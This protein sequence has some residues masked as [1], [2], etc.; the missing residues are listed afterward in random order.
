M[1]KRADAKQAHSNAHRE[2]RAAVAADMRRRRG[3]SDMTLAEH[4][5]KAK[6]GEIP[7]TEVTDLSQLAVV[8][9]SRNVQVLDAFAQDESEDSHFRAH[10]ART[11]AELAIK[12]ADHI[13]NSRPE[14]DGNSPQRVVVVRE[15]D[16]DAIERSLMAEAG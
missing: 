9:F 13:V 12:L 8:M 15:Q 16:M 2:M 1:S 5:A 14:R 4:F 11:G 6:A 7:L 10:C 3:L